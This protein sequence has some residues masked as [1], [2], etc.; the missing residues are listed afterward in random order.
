MRPS[1][2]SRTCPPAR[3]AS[4]SSTAPT[5]AAPCRGRSSAACSRRTRSSS[6][7]PRSTC[8]LA[9][10]AVSPRSRARRRSRPGTR[11]CPRPTRPPP[12]TPSW[13]R[14]CPA[15]AGATDSVTL[16]QRLAAALGVEIGKATH[17]ERLRGRVAAI[18]AAHRGRLVARQAGGYADETPADASAMWTT[19]VAGGCW[20]DEPQGATLVDVRSPLPSLAS[21]EGWMKPA[22]GEPGQVGL[23]AFAARGT[24]GTTPV[25]PLLTKLYQESDLRPVGRDGGD[26][27]EDGRAPGPRRPPA[28]P[29][30][31]RG[32]RRPRRAAD[33]SDCSRRRGSRS[34]PGPT[35]PLCTRRRAR[36]PKEPCP[37]R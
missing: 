33:R 32:R 31:E 10:E 6:A 17:E 20:I 1:P 2:L 16:A 13:H 15:P 25:S 14:C 4:C 22:A 24:A 28:G 37:W 8:G 12:A 27:P 19:L 30:R 29:D 26:E 11:C 9:G 7:C 21:L 3:W 18:H 35:R 36:K 5:T 23:V 34:P